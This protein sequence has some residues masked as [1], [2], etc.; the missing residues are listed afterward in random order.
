MGLTKPKK[1]GEREKNEKLKY[2]IEKKE[3][4]GNMMKE[5]EKKK[6]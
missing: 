5:K 2:T 4:P 3:N 1:N 6:K